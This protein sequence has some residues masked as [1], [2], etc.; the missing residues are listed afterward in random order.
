MLRTVAGCSRERV[1][2]SMFAAADVVFVTSTRYDTI[3]QDTQ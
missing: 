3:R 1:S 2:G